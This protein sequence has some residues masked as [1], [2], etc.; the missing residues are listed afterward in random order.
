MTGSSQYGCSL[1]SL[2]TNEWDEITGQSAC[3]TSEWKGF[4][5]GDWLIGTSGLL[6][7]TPDDHAAAAYGLQTLP[8]LF[9][10]LHQNASHDITSRSIRDYP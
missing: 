9:P 2:W 7:R 5:V 4:H 3:A 6:P 1:G 10:T 8:L